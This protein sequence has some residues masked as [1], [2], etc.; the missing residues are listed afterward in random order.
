MKSGILFASIRAAIEA[1]NSGKYV[2]A[3]E[4]QGLKLLRQTTPTSHSANDDGSELKQVTQPKR[5]Y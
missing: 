5:W 3:K 2:K 1:A 4:P